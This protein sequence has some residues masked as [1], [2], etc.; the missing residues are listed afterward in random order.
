MDGVSEKKMWELSI[1]ATEEAEIWSKWGGYIDFNV[2]PH[3]YFI[4]FTNC[5]I[6]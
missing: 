6:L 3:E 4:K 1:V 5:H 2:L